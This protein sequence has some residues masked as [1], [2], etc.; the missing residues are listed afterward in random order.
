MEPPKRRQKH[1]IRAEEEEPENEQ[2]VEPPV[3]IFS[4]KG[5]EQVL[6]DDNSE[7]DQE[8]LDVDIKAPDTQ[9]TQTTAE[10]KNLLDII[11]EIT[12]DEPAAAKHAPAATQQTPTKSSAVTLKGSSKCK[13]TTSKGAIAVQINSVKCTRRQ[14]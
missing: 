14:I 11:A 7:D 3:P 1:I 2:D 8:D 5:K 4:N 9:V 12:A 10:K 6:S 13:E